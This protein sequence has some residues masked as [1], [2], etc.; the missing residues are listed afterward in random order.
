MPRKPRLNI[1]GAV[2]HVM[3][4]CL[5]HYS[6]FFDDEDREQFLSLLGLYINQTEAQCY[7]WVLM[8]N[9]YHLVLRLGDKEL[10]RIM[11]PLN[12]HYAHY[13]R[14]KYRR[15]GPLFMDRFKS[16]AT[17]NQHYVQ[18]LV[19]YVHLNP[20][21]AG[22]CK[23]IDDLNVYPWSGHA[24]LAGAGC[25]NRSFQE[26]NSVLKRFGTT[27][28]DSRTNYLKFMAEGLNCSNDGDHLVCLVRKS[29]E[30]I[31]SGRTA[32]CWVIGDR[33]FVMNALE[34]AQAGRLRVSRFEREGGS[35]EFIAAKIC[36][37]FNVSADELK[38]RHR[39]STTADARK[40]LAC[41]ADREY[42]APH[43]I[44]AGYLGVGTTAVSEMSRQ[45]KVIVDRMKVT[46]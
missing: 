38:K 1:P 36:E 20:V 10:G 40:V 3:S 33:E 12:M 28:Q 30:G 17:Q 23:S 6:I 5:E 29:N 27:I 44:I 8:H 16:I 7:A 11:K 24:A 15:R 13:H 43:R 25:K 42:R 9:H 31:Q 22:I 45:G 32:T 18:E 19:R 41:I 14:K 2:Y 26:T 4:R 46:I 35:I 21:R 39:G 37:Q 34:S